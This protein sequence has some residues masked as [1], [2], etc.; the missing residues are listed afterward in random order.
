MF[1]TK[2]TRTKTLNA[3]ESDLFKVGSGEGL[4]F[5]ATGT[6]SISRL[7]PITQVPILLGTYTA[8]ASTQYGPFS[9]DAVLQITNTT[10]T[11]QVST[12]SATEGLVIQAKISM[13]GVSPAVGDK[14]YPVLPV[15][16]TASDGNLLINRGAGNVLL[17]SGLNPYT[18]QAGDIPPQGSNWPITATGVPS[19]MTSQ[20]LNISSPATIPGTPAAPTLSASGTTLSAAYVAPSTG[21]SAITSYDLQLFDSNGNLLSTTLGVANPAVISN[22]VAIGGSYKVKVRANNAV[23]SGAYSPFS[24]TVTIATPSTSVAGMAVS[25]GAVGAFAI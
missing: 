22:G 20:P 6:G 24:N 25:S 18:L 8:G 15:G 2:K 17:Q 21:G 10:G 3:G 12:T 19:A 16:W 9:P 4:S 1:T 5:I 13:A 23:G 11:V 7:D 14:V